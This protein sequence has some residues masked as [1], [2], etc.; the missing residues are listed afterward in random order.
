M[1]TVDFLHFFLLP[2][3]L[4]GFCRREEV[5]KQPHTAFGISTKVMFSI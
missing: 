4:T 1:F 3:G 5:T 2:L